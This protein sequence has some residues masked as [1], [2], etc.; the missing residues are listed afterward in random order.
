MMAH[1]PY[2]G[3]TKGSGIDSYTTTIY[4]DFHCYECGARFSQTVE[5]FVDDWGMATT[6]LMCPACEFVDT[7]SFYLAEVRGG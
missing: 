3:S 5:V 7:H 2:D 4:K 6:E 1:D